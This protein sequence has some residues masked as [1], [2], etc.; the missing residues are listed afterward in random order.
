MFG[1]TVEGRFKF[2]VHSFSLFI[3]ATKRC[4]AFQ[5]DW[6]FIITS[7]RRILIKY[8]YVYSNSFGSPIVRLWTKTLT[9]ISEKPSDLSIEIR[10][11][12]WLD[13]KKR[14]ISEYSPNKSNS[15]AGRNQ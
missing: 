13:F 10:N 2:N 6:N 8:I 4:H 12:F 11:C 15:L 7:K 3:E 14:Q 9:K 5:R 1:L